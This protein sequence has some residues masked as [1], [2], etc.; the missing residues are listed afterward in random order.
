MD[1][2][3]ND[4]EKNTSE[5]ESHEENLGD[6]ESAVPTLVVGEPKRVKISHPASRGAYDRL[7]R[8]LK[9]ENRTGD[10]AR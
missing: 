1:P 8:R 5:G 9:A 2:K 7:F 6:K 10:F 3:I 4:L